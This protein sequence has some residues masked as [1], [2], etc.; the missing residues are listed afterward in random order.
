MIDIIL[1]AKKINSQ[2]FKK[3]GE[4]INF[5][6]NKYKYINNGFAKKFD[7][8][9]K[10]RILKNSG[11]VKFSIFISKPRKFPLKIE[12][13]ERH[14]LSTQLFF[15]ISKYGFIVVVCANKNKPSINEIKSF[16][17]P[18][19]IGINYKI[20][21]WH[22]PL[23]TKYKSNFIVIDSKSLKKNIEIFKF[24]KQNIILNDAR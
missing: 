16:I 15:P 14:P 6:K 3:F 24:N 22:Y 18:P 1:K 21:I 8:L 12:M 13:L 9:A 19:N 7:N 2:N 11:K 23:I 10:I 5:N 20:G 4:V 17:I